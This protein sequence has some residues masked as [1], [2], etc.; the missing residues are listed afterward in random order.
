MT[1]PTLPSLSIVGRAIGSSDEDSGSAPS[2]FASMPALDAAKRKQLPAWIR[3]GLEK[4]EREKQKRE[5]RQQFLQNR[6][7]RRKQ[8]LLTSSVDNET[9]LTRSRFDDDEDDEQDARDEDIS[10]RAVSPPAKL[11][12]EDLVISTNGR[13]NRSLL[14][15]CSSHVL[16]FFTGGRYST[17]NDRN[18]FRGNDRRNQ[19][20]CK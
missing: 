2:S 16:F 20:C 5:E 10:A 8:D 15:H 1:Q 12:V 7:L 4:M 6:E 19:N 14:L 18:S 3:E 11:Q 17:F 9:I 13:R